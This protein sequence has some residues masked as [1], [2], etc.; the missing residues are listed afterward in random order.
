[1]A[2]R[3]DLRMA[4]IAA[5]R[6]AERTGLDRIQEST[7]TINRGMSDPANWLLGIGS[8]LL[9]PFSGGLSVG[10]AIVAILRATK[11]GKAAVQAVTPTVADLSAPGP[12]CVRMLAAGGVMVVTLFIVL[13]FLVA[14]YMNAAGIPMK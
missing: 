1:M 12:G 7:N 10:L 3:Y 2:S 11:N 4:E 14:L 6:A 8:I 13:L 5:Q 9:L